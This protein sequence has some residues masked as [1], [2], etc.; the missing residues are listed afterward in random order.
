MDKRFKSNIIS[1]GKYSS[2]RQS[3]T[4]DPKIKSRKNKM[5]GITSL[6]DNVCISDSSV[7]QMDDV[8]TAKIKKVKKDNL[9]ISLNTEN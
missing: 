4:N 6:T 8:V 7:G 5:S 2:A 1:G 9:K 3:P